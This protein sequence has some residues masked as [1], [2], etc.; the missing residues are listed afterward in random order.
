MKFLV[1]SIMIIN[2]QV[3]AQPN[4]RHIDSIQKIVD[5]N[6]TTIA[7]KFDTTIRVTVSGSHGESLSHSI[8]VELSFDKFDRIIRIAR[9]FKKKE[10]FYYFWFND[11]QLIMIEG[12]ELDDVGTV[13][14]GTYIRDSF[15]RKLLEVVL[16]I[17]NDKK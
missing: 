2:C 3:Q 9:H 10:L 15:D 8:K 13:W 11:E 17:V 1:F 5:I 7:F 6:E 4:F 14:S 12:N 16:P